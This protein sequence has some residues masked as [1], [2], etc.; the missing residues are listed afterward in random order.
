M[1]PLS[2]KKK[3]SRVAWQVILQGLVAVDRM[4]K[5]APEAE[6]SDYKNVRDQLLRAWK[7][8][9]LIGGL[10][11]K[12]R[13]YDILPDSIMGEMQLAG[14]KKQSRKVQAKAKRDITVPNKRPAA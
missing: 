9:V 8:G 6:R 5:K 13:I 14:L 7:S 4:M 11:P 10:R 2:L 1:R 3:E 12:H